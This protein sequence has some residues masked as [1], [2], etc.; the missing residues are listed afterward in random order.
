MV[1]AHVTVSGGACVTCPWG[2]D[3]ARI[4]YVNIHDRDY[5]RNHRIRQFLT[6]RGH[7]VVPDDRDGVYGLIR[8]STRILAAGLRQRGPFDVIILS[9]LGLK[10][11]AA[12]RIVALRHRA[13]L[14]SDA[15]I[16][17]Y[18][19]N[20]EDRKRTT[21]RYIR[22]RMYRI[23]DHIAA[24]GSSACLTDTIVRKRRILADGARR[25]VV[26]PV[27]APDWAHYAP[28]KG[29]QSRVHVLYYGNYIPLHGLTYVIDAIAAIVDRERF[30]FTFVG[31]GPGRPPI[32]DAAW[33]AGVHEVIQWLDYMPPEDLA[34]LL[35]ESD[36][37]LGV[38]GT[39][40]KAATVLANKVWQGLSV[41][42]YV[43][44]RETEAAE[45]VRPLVE[46]QLR[47]VDPSDPKAL[48]ECLSELSDLMVTAP[49]RP[50]FPES[51]RRLEDYVGSMYDDLDVAIKELT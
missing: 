16:G 25:V 18:E 15:F 46:D 22:A 33:S 50:T 20:V 40:P 2:G 10:Y 19:S 13:L 11:V 12:A 37:V 49:H 28:R 32:E 41:G 38:F 45:E 29:D 48:T 17:L 34:N 4:L 3:V 36:I 21:E 7:E 8:G 30:R 1:P 47:T 31:E 27:G 14:V 26:L 24:R 43:V 39:S 5:P 23:A 35:A 51:E 9:E 42:R 44:T 6:A